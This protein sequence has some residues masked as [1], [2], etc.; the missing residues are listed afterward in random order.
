MPCISHTIDVK[1]L[2]ATTLALLFIL[3]AWG[4]RVFR[5]NY[6]IKT[7]LIKLSGTKLC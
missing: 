5:R 3:P 2:Q 6:L 1:T 7:L 4:I